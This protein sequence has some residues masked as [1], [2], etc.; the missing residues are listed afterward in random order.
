MSVD[1]F[2]KCKALVAKAAAPKAV[3]VGAVRRSAPVRRAV[4]GTKKKAGFAASGV[5]KGAMLGA[6]AGAAVLVCSRIP[7]PLLGHPWASY[8]PPATTG[9]LPAGHDGYGSFAQNIL[10]PFGGSNGSTY[11][12]LPVGAPGER[13][14]PSVSAEMVDAAFNPTGLVGSVQAVSEPGTLLLVMFGLV[15]AGLIVAFTRKSK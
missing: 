1:F 3:A 5:A 13:A 7:M 6:G 10:Y 4:I 12:L 8:T 2:L 11:G 14:T 9:Y 15:L